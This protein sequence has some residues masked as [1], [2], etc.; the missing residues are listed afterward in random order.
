MLTHPQKSQNWKGSRKLSQ[1]CENE[2]YDD[3]EDKKEKTVDKTIK[4]YQ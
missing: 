4:N 1:C 3:T 2:C